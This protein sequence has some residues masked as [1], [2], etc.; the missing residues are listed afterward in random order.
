MDLKQIN[1]RD[2]FVL[3]HDGKYYM[4]GTRGETAFTKEAFGFDVYVSKDL[5]DWDGPIEIFKRPEGFFSKKYYWAPEVYHIDGRFFMFATFADQKKWLGTMALVS[6]DPCGP[7]VPWSDGYLTPKD[8]RCLDGTLYVDKH[9]NRHIVFCHE[10][11]QVHD[12]EVCALKL[13]DDFKG[14][15]GKH[16]ILFKASMA[17][18]YVKRFM[19]R[20]YVTDGPFLLRTDDGKLHMLWS[21]YGKTGYV[22]AMAHSD[23]DEIDGNWKPDEELLFSSDGGHG[24]IF[25]DLEGNYKLALH[26]PNTAFKEHPVFISLKYENGRFIAENE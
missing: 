4:Y 10:W 12:G 26:S 17:V 8:L 16:R 5:K 20:N 24:M 25:Q 2:P 9:G 21:T 7:F 19:F 18:P 15:T 14:C 22:Q 13:R 6:D 1:I 3:V 23:N 11:K